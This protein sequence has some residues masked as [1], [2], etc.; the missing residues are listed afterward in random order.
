MTKPTG[1]PTGRPLKNKDEG[2]GI[3]KSVRLSQMQWDRVDTARGVTPEN[4]DGDMSRSDLIDALIRE[5]TPARAE[6]RRREW[7]GRK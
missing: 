4:P 6:E 5:D 2:P 1:E 3:N 7:R